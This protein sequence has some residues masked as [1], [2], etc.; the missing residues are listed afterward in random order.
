MALTR[1]GH[2]LEGGAEFSIASSR[3]GTHMEH[4]RCQRCQALDVCVPGRG[5]DDA[6]APLILVLREKKREK[7]FK[8]VFL[9][10]EHLDPVCME[11]INSLPLP[12]SNILKK[13]I[14][15]TVS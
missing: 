13:R 11:C 8:V 4:I 3:A 6:I 5:F 12:F 14:I 1:V 9:I 10:S 15:L 2:E 7:E